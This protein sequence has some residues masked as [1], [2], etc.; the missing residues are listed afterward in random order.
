MKK[1][2]YKL[3]WNVAATSV[4]ALALTAC[5]QGAVSEN[6]QQGGAGGATGKDDG[7]L[8]IGFSMD[9]LK[10][11]RWQKDRELFEAKV[12]ELGAE[13]LTQ[14]ANGD[15]A[16]QLAQAENLISQGV[17]VLVVVPHNAEATAAIV[18]KAHAA[19]I[20]VVSY[21]RLI[22]NSEVDL[23]VSFDNEK[24]G[25][26]QAKAIIEKA[27]T[28]NYVYIGGADTDNNAVLFRKGAM[29]I[30]EPLAKEGKINIV[31]DQYSKDWKP[32]EALKNMENALTANSNN[33]Q[34]V[35]AANDGTAG[36][37][38]QALTAQGLV[39]KVPVSGQDAELA[40][41]Q[42]IVEGKQTMTVY[43]PIKKLADTV[44]EL[45]VKL[46][47]N[48]AVEAPAKVNNGKI[49]VP[50]LLL[51]PVA[52]NKDNV[53]DTVVADGFHKLEDV[54]KNVPQDQWPKK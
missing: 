16:K 45:S 6:V 11:E 3:I 30:L 31:F 22:K 53:A 17:D 42:R 46:A 35:V 8:V 36:G 50:S 29:N 9:T 14:A 5:G 43:K 32:E 47:K 40:A 2:S 23:Y 51:E 41:L 1:K 25:E 54:F 52:V 26:I 12:K 27:P 20:K 38:I 28:G 18:E 39:G 21:D 37:V 13:V 48:E 49:D 15:D 10:E 7:K 44:A 4:L 33:I 34:A 19:G 24:V